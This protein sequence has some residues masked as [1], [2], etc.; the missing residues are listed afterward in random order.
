MITPCP[1][2]P[3]ADIEHILAHTAHLWR[4][5]SGSRIFITGGTGFFGKWVLESIAA[6]NDQLDANTRATILTRDPANF[7]TEVQHLA[8]RREF[9]WLI[10]D[11]ASF[12][13]PAAAFDHVF[14]FS[15][16]SAAEVGAGNTTPMMATLL[17]TARVLQFARASGA[18]RLLFTSSGAIYERQP[19]EL[20]HI[21]EDY[22]GAP[23]L[24]DPASAY[25]E[26]KRR[27]E[28]MC[29]FA[30]G[31]DCVIVRGFSFIGPYL[32]LTDK[33]AAGSF[34]RDALAGGPIRIHGDGRPIRSYM[35]GADLVIWLL[36][37][38]LKG[39]PKH[40]YNVGSDQAISLADLAAEILHSSGN[41]GSIE[42]GQAQMNMG[43]A[44]Y[45]PSIER[46]RSELGLTVHVPL[47]LALRRTIEWARKLTK[48]KSP[49]RQPDRNSANNPAAA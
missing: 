10:G 5:L 28:S 37:L 42:T 24:T 31:V 45:V 34:I 3:A 14:H 26:L 12:A 23:D 25:G 41:L 47:Q 35:Y 44:R 17:G 33:F 27:C 16:A 13:F 32:P 49:L 22:R 19:P 6:A 11:T 21:S 15:T 8:A 36:T 7:Q 40:P 46:A 43:A 18:H 1:P 2:L 4:E 20:D 30:A 38:L 9:D 39:T 29:V 48:V